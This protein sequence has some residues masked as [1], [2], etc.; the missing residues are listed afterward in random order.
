MSKKNS[1]PV[2]KPESVPE[3]SEAEITL[4]NMGKRPAPNLETQNEGRIMDAEKAETDKAEMAGSDYKDFPDP[5]P[6]DAP[7]NMPSDDFDPEGIVPAAETKALTGE[8]F[9]DYSEG[10]VGT[11]G[12]GVDVGGPKSILETGAENLYNVLYGTP[13]NPIGTIN[14]VHKF[15]W[16]GKDISGNHHVGSGDNASKCNVDAGLQGS[17]TCHIALNPDYVD[18]E[19]AVASVVA[20]VE[21]NQHYQKGHQD[22][23][24]Y[25]EDVKALIL[26]WAS[27]QALSGGVQDVD[28]LPFVQYARHNP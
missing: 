3:K 5:S 15:H 10:P 17:A 16:H 27:E 28:A 14:P 2:A 18:P 25:F 26:A 7:T 22:G 12:F 4:E 9:K 8:E 19:D 11:A 20:P 1:K 24:R 6:I 13:A 23:F 21:A